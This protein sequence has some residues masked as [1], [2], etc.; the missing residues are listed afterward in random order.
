MY[1]TGIKYENRTGDDTDFFTFSLRDDVFFIELSKKYHKNIP[2]RTPMFHTRYGVYVQIMTLDHFRKLLR[3]NGFDL[4]DPSCL[5]NVNAVTK[6]VE[7]E[8]GNTAYFENGE[9]I[10]VSRP[11]ANK[12]QHLVQKAE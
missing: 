12:Y 4:L 5:V 3:D 11:M 9:S 7:H 6:I 10:P 1:I 8:Y 2:L